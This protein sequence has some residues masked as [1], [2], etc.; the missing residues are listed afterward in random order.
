MVGVAGCGRVRDV[1][2]LVGLWALL[3]GVGRRFGGVLV[4]AGGFGGAAGVGQ[5]L[6]RPLTLVSPPVPSSSEV[7]GVPIMLSSGSRVSVV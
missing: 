5:D 6:L 3:G 2:C 4:V 1:G 7:S